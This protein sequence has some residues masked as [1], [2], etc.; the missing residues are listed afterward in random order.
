MGFFTFMLTN[1]NERLCYDSKAYLVDND[2]NEW[3]EPCYQGYG[4]F[5]G[6]DIFELIAKMNGLE[7]RKGGIALLGIYDTA[8]SKPNETKENLLRWTRF[9]NLDDR[10]IWDLF[11]NKSAV[12]PNLNDVKG[13]LWENVTLQQ[14]SQFA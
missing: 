4:E 10:K 9:E 12:F 2:G 11:E 3:V 1:S 14:A 6:Q 13:M 5:G 8:R 7:T